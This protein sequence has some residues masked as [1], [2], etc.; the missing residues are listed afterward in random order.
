LK[1]P[2]SVPVVITLSWFALFLLINT[3]D[4]ILQVYFRVPYF[5]TLAALSSC[6]AAGA[7]EVPR[8]LVNPLRRSV[9]RQ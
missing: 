6:C 1:G 7:P 9:P 5:F 3:Y 2:I 8:A 4:S